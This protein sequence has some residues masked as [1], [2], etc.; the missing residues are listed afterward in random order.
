[1]VLKVAVAGVT[2]R[3]GRSLV[4]AIQLDRAVQLTTATVRAHSPQRGRDVGE[5]CGEGPLGVIATDQLDAQLFDVMI[6]FTSPEYSLML[7]QYCCE[8]RKPLVLGTTGF[9][10]QQLQQLQQLSQ[11]IAIVQAANT[12]VGIIVLH[13]LIQH[14]AQVMGQDS[15]IEIIEAH[16]RD[17]VD[18]PSGTALAL[19]NTVA[20]A[21][22][23][24]LAQH[25]VYG[26]QGKEGPRK[27]Q[28][29]GFSTIRGGDIVG[30]HTVLFAAQGERLEIT[31]KAS[32]RMTFA[33]GAVRAA[34][35]LQHQGAGLYSMEDVVQGTCTQK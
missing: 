28:T 9:E 13:Q 24:S 30:E 1:M 26:R 18:A 3:M 17:K 22:N 27:K 15:D 31:H 7:A 6:D 16:H 14:V 8:H 11:K 20:E 12:S 29:I 35:W 4:Q 25:A 33:K 23:R 32:G 2:G 21:L 19:G 34:K 10:P 5:L